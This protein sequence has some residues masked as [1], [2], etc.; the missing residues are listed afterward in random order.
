[1]LIAGVR[2]WKLKITLTQGLRREPLDWFA[3]SLALNYPPE[4][5]L[6]TATKAFWATEAG[7]GR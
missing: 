3:S 1:V 7:N 4:L 2:I 6:F 5:I